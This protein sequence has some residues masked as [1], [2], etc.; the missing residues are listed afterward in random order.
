MFLDKATIFC[1]A[2]DGGDGKVSFRRE[3]F[4]PNGGPDGGDGGKGGDIV[5]VATKGVGNLGDFRYT[6]HFRA[7]NGENGGS[8]R[9]SGKSGKD[10]VI[11]VPE[12]TVI[13]NKA[14]GKVVAD[15]LHDG[16]EFVLLKGGMGGRGNQHFA[17]ATRQAPMYS[18][19]GVKTKEWELVL[20]LKTIA[21]VGL[22]GFPNVGKSTFLASVSNARPKIANYHFT[23]LAPNIGVVKAYDTSFVVADIPGLISGASEGVGL[24][25]D[26]LRHIERTRLLVHLVDISG[27]EG[28]DPYNDYEAINDELS[29]YSD[30]VANLPQIVALNKIDLVTDRKIV[31]DF[32]KKLPKGTQVFEISA[33]AYLGLDDLIKAI[34]EKLRD[35]PPSE[36]VEIEETNIDA[37]TERTFEVHKLDATTYEVTGNMVEEI[38]RRVVIEDYTSNAYFQRQLKEKGIIDA[39]ID[40][41]MKDGDTVRLAGLEWEYTE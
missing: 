36:G 19:L 17:T 10:V 27:S 11:K 21:D 30:K 6:K 41:G 26:F 16:Q 12:G 7:E 2:G 1:K 3:K 33:A 8:Y 14:T 35:L 24:G 38:T 37:V 32:K 13:R 20:E 34:V 22:V 39:L 9:C 18:E 29:H 28:R 31:D 25:L 15:M 40:A 4:V 5:F 23:T